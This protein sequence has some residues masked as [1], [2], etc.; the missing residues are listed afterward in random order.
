MKVREALLQQG[1]PRFR[2]RL[3]GANSCG[4]SFV[5][6]VP[7][8]ADSAILLQGL[9]RQRET[10]LE[11][12]GRLLLK[13]KV[14]SYLGMSYKRAVRTRRCCMLN[15]LS[16][17]VMCFINHTYALNVWGNAC[18][19]D[20]CSIQYAIEELRQQLQESVQAQE[21]IKAEARQV[22]GSSRS[23]MLLSCR[24]LRRRY[25]CKIFNHLHI[26]ISGGCS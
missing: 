11:E 1:W 5:E 6:Y 23:L 4:S 13:S 18:K 19:E 21:D 17:V 26:M 15:H 9:L 25:S 20:L 8:Y 2:C 12:R 10:E 3:C 16:Q 22:C 24:L 7:S 14:L